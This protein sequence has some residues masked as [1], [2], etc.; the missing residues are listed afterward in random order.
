[1]LENI[2]L[3]PNGKVD[4]ARLT[5]AA[6]DATT[7]SVETPQTETEERLAR[8]W[9]EVLKKD[10]VGVTDNFLDL[11]GH[12]LMAIRML[13]RISKTFGLR[14][15]LRTLFD[16]PTVRQLADIVDTELKLAALENMSDEEAERL[17]GSSAGDSAT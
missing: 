6:E 4:V 10:V 3:T 1:L 2:P 8:I 14:L 5:A 12:S 11:G 13:G 17:L 9:A 15:S 16:A 7:A